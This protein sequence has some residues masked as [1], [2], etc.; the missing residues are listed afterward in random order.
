[1]GSNPI[2]PTGPHGSDEEAGPHLASTGGAAAQP[3]K[4]DIIGPNGPHTAPAKPN[5]TAEDIGPS[6]PHT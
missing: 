1:M 3:T 5:K 4:E 2:G 6:G